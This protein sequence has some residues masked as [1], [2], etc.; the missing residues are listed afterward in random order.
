MKEEKVAR[1]V[2]VD[3]KNY[4]TEEMRDQELK[5]GLFAMD[6]DDDNSDKEDEDSSNE[7]I[8]T[9]VTVP[10]TRKRR[11]REQ[12]EK[13]A[14]RKRKEEKAKRIRDNQV[15]RTKTL[16]SEIAKGKAASKAKQEKKKELESKK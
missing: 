10:K 2:Y 6:S 7:E 12:M 14:I 9:T 8:H 11:R 1:A 13:D 16:I 15:F 5:E 4:V 3:P